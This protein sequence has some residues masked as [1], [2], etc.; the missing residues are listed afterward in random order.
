METVTNTKLQLNRKDF[1]SGKTLPIKILQFGEGNFLRAFVDYAFHQL[2][3]KLDYNAG[4]AAV[5]PLPGGMVEMLNEQDAMY[6][7][8]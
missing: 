4:V 2:N 7:V 8:F 6:T 1:G 3:Q 5:Q